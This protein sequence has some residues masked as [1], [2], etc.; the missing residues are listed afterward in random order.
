[1]PDDLTILPDRGQLQA[2]GLDNVP[3]LFTDAGGPR[4]RPVHLILHAE[5]PKPQHP[6]GVRPRRPWFCCWCEDHG[7]TRPELTPFLVPG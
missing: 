5:R 4:R 6:R 7:L 3:R 2:A 1:M